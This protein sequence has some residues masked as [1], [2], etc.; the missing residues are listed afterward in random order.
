VTDRVFLPAHVLDERYDADGFGPVEPLAEAL[1]A[2][3]DLA[4]G[5]RLV[6][7]SGAT[8]R[9]GFFGR[10]RRAAFL[11]PAVRGAALL[12]R[13]YVDVGGGRSSPDHP[14][15]LVWGYVVPAG[16]RV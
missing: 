15:D 13:G 16:R 5:E 4:P 8:P 10:F 14:D 7:P 12:A 1:P 11:H 9:A 2:P 3:E 6:I